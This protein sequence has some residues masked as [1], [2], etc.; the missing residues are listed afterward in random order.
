MTSATE[1]S[2]PD[3]EKLADAEPRLL[4][5]LTPGELAI[6]FVLGGL[7]SVAAGLVALAFWGPGRWHPAGA[8]GHPR[9]LD[10]PR[11]AQG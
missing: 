1:A 3:S 10:H 7:A 4:L 11:A 9:G 8:A 2:A 5:G 6:R